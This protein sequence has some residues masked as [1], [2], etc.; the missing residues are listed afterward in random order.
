MNYVDE[1]FKKKK[2]CTK[3]LINNKTYNWLSCLLWLQNV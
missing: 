3:G 2:M 1:F